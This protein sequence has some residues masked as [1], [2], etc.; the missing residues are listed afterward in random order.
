MRPE[1]PGAACAQPADPPA[2]TPPRPGR[3]NCR[4]SSPSASACTTSARA[5]PS[6]PRPRPGE[7][8]LAVLLVI[9]F[10]AHNATEGFGIVAPLAAA[11][12][13]PTWGRLV[14]SASSAAAPPSWAPWSARQVTPRSRHRL[15][16]AGGRL[17]PVR[18]DRAARRGPRHQAQGAGHLGRSCS[19]WCSASSPTRSSPP[20]APDTAGSTQA[21]CG[22]AADSAD[23]LRWT[24]AQASA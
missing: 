1:G 12:E 11:G 22:L 20:P 21:G 5:W 15:P 6:A 16:G 17:D 7:L 23:G 2:R 8:S 18:R 24:G 4:C 3:R 9:G 13:R 14:C 10:G 19:G